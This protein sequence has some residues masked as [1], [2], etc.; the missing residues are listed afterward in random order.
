MTFEL[1]QIITQ[2]LAFLIMLW[3]LKRYA[4]KPLL[5]F[6]QE[7]TDK[8]EA[9]FK[10]IE[11]KNHRADARLEEYHHKI[12]EL[13]KEGAV[14]IDHAI[15]KGQKAAHDLHVE[16][17]RK[18][19]ELIEKAREQIE[20]DKEKARCEL[21]NEIVNLTCTAV[22]KL[23]RVKMTPEELNGLSLQLMDER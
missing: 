6:M 19:M 15:K 23:V 22:E 10:E 14:I 20:R 17:Q 7:R 8:I 5:E 3:I 21:K 18:T 4:W 11:T 2:I 12:Q 1:K 16:A 9:A 13:Q